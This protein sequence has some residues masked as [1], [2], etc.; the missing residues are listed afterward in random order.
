M[1]S[2]AFVGATAAVATPTQ[3]ISAKTNGGSGCL[4][5]HR[6]QGIMR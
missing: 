6:A 5:R 1:S 4:I 3:F 2:V